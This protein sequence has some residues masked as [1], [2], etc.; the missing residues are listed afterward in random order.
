M[1]PILGIVLLL[2]VGCGSDIAKLRAR[3][4]TIDGHA[5]DIRTS[6][7]ELRTEQPPGVP[8]PPQIAAIDRSAEHIVGEVK[9]AQMAAEGVQD[10][11]TVLER[12]WWIVG[13]GVFLAIIVVGYSVFRI[14][15]SKMVQTGVKLAAVGAGVIPPGLPRAVERAIRP[16]G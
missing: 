12:I 14:M 15:R 7:A 10:K 13:A 6:V 16:R 9:V 1:R 11:P 4:V 2:A 8:E 3:L 5:R